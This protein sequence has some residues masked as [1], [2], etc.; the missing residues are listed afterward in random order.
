[1]KLRGRTD[2][3]KHGERREIFTV[4]MAVQAELSTR[5]LYCKKTSI[6]NPVYWIAEEPSIVLVTGQS[7]G[8]RPPQTKLRARKRK[9]RKNF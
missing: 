8:G 2:D 4:D 1:M 7:D 3:S 9:T 6:D 5:T